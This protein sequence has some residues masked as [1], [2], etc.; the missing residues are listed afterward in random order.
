[1]SNIGKIIR[2]N[3]LPPAGTRENNVIYQVAAQG[4]ATY[5]DYAVDENGDI[6]THAGYFD[7]QDLTDHSV[8]ISTQQ[9][10]EEG[11][12]TQEEFNIDI[13]EKVDNKVE[14]PII[15]GTPQSYPKIVGL[16]AYGNTAALRA[17]DIGKNI[18]NSSLTSVAG[19]GLTLGADWT[20]ETAGHHYSISGLKDVSADSTFKTFVSQNDSGE[21]GKTNGIQPFLS[22]PNTLSESDKIAWKTAMNGGWTTNTMSVASIS[23]PVVDSRDKTYY[24][25]LRGT[26]L[27][28]S[29]TSFKIELMDDTT[30]EIV[31]AEIPNNQ[32]QLYSNGVDLVFYYNFKNIPVGT[33]R[34]RLWNGI[35]HYVT[36]A[37]S[38]IKVLTGLTPISLG[39]ITWQTIQQTPGINGVVNASGN[40]I[41]FQNKTENAALG[42]TNIVAA[43]KSS[44]II[45]NNKNFYLKGLL[46]IYGGT[47]NSYGGAIV[48]I[49]ADSNLNLINGTSVYVKGENHPHYGSFTKKFYAGYSGIQL[50][51]GNVHPGTVEFIMIRNANNATIIVSHGSQTIIANQT[52]TEDAAH[53][54]IYSMNGADENE[55]N[56]YQIVLTDGYE[57]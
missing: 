47:R 17:S 52:I 6:K 7:P 48:G 36:G 21:L 53:M 55:L 42:N 38:T 39:N 18:A 30:A 1:M 4:A 44:E 40:T 34:I 50:E 25:T 51:T 41:A 12:A 54:Y 3:A 57:F 32:V 14:K 2:V 23:P 19:S 49:G 15:N 28:L 29:P 27:N 26:N 13:R 43:V 46:S 11:L 8:N 9:F 10:S 22:L 5:T 31:I 45:G 33:Y 35:A 37:I 24:F 16:D 20:V 56:K